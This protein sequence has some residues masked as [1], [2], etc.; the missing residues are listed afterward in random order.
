MK[1]LATTLLLLLSPMTFAKSL[2]C[3]AAV[4]DMTKNT[5]DYFNLIDKLGVEDLSETEVQFE[6]SP[7]A[8]RNLKLEIDPTGSLWSD[9]VSINSEDNQ[10]SYN[11]TVSVENNLI[12]RISIENEVKHTGTGVSNKAGSKSLE[13]SSSDLETYIDINCSVLE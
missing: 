6:P 9:A 8:Q 10:A 12:T 13:A 4:Y 11:F 3:T 2:T 1:V 7:I 5:Q